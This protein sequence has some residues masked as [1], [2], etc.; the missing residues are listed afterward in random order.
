MSRRVVVVGGLVAVGG[1]YWFMREAKGVAAGIISAEDALAGVVA[2]TLVLIDIRRPDEWGRTGIARGAQPL[3]M[4]RDDFDRALLELVGG[5]RDMPMALICA[6]G[7][8]SHRMVRRLTRAGFTD[9]LDVSEGMLGSAAGPG[10]LA[11]GLP[12]EQPA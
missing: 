2:G 9:V 4:R 6:R 5:V 1:A 12:V 7:V 3:D 10:W 11:R 8:R